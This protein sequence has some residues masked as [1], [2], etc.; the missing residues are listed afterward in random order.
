MSFQPP[1]V[2][3]RG[4]ELDKREV[5]L[6]I[7]ALGK[8]RSNATGTVTLTPNSATTVV[9]DPNAG[10]T[11]VISFMPTTANA[12]NE[13]MY[14]SAQSQGSFTITHGNTPLADRTFSYAIQG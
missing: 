5:A 13:S 9:S 6:A 10:E 11:S 1:I 8:G 4:A 2:T 7:D 3:S 14:V 12:A